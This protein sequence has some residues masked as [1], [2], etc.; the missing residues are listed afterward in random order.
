M[1]LFLVDEL[2]TG[3]QLTL[4]GAEARHAVTVRRIRAGEEILVGDGRGGT[5]ACVVDVVH[6]GREPSLE[7]TVHGRW[8][9]PQP[10]L[11]VRI[12]QALVK[13]DRGELAVELA[14]EAGADAVVPWQAERCV[15]RWDGADRQA[16]GLARW[17]AS[18]QAAAKQAERPWLPPVLDPVDTAELAEL[19]RVADVGIVAD[20]AAP[21]PLPQI[22]V[23]DAG[24]VVVVIGPEGGITGSERDVLVAA[25]AVPA[26]LGPSVLRSSTAAAVALGA[27]G[28]CTVRWT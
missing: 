17:R 15:A 20:T 26:R 21:T 27:L 8:F 16:K 1:S 23:P 18:S 14:T 12:A 19:I 25:G 9:V 13:G 24:T 3:T 5:A 6:P 4:T 28:A 10:A 11:Q 7:A 22:A 2:P